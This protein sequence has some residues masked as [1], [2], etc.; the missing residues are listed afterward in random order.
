M[1][2]IYKE[3]K[4]EYIEAGEIFRAENK[5]HSMESKS[6]KELKKKIEKFRFERIPVFC[7]DYWRD[8]KISEG[9][10][11]SVIGERVW[12]TYGKDK[13]RAKV[14]ISRLF[15]HTLENKK[16]IDQINV[17]Y[18]EKEKIEKD[19]GELKNKI[20]RLKTTDVIKD[21]EE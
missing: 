10:I 16:I 7:N 4:I 14:T 3:W 18:A 19:I 11:T 20:E 6:L 12:V 15:K 13:Q 17:K 5:D 8:S 21:E 1:E 9:E 2:E